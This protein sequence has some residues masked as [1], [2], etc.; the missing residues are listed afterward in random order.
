MMLS[1]KTLRQV[2]QLTAVNDHGGA[3]LLAAQSLGCV[4]LADLFASINQQHLTLGHLPLNLYDERYAAYQ[5]LM[6][7]AQANMSDSDY[8]EFYAAF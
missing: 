3:Y 7:F 5:A 8:Q 6:K 1:A 4:E 2:K